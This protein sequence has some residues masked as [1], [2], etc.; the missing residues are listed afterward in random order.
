MA[1]KGV[2]GL[3]TIKSPSGRQVTWKGKPLYSFIADSAGKVTGNGKG[4]VWFVVK[5]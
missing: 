4:K 5:V 3:G 2:T 1:P